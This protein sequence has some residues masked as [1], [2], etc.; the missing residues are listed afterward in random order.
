MLGSVDAGSGCLLL[1]RLLLPVSTWP[2]AR[3]GLGRVVL[4]AL[5]PSRLWSLDSLPCRI[6]LGSISVGFPKMPTL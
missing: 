3:W 4:V 5:V 1:C 6:G 2:F